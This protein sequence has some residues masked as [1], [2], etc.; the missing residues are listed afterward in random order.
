MYT[1]RKSESACTH[2]TKDKVASAILALGIQ[3]RSHVP[4]STGEDRFIIYII[5]YTLHML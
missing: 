5:F 4:N 1:Y 2:S 3:W